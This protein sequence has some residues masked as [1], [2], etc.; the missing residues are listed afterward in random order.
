MEIDAET[1]TP[2]VLLEYGIVK[3]LRARRDEVV[4]LYPDRTARKSQAAGAG[5]THVIRFI[6]AGQRLNYVPG[7]LGSCHAR[8]YEQRYGDFT[9]VHRF[10][11]LASARRCLTA[12]VACNQFCAQLY[13]PVKLKTQMR[14]LACLF[15]LEFEQVGVGADNQ[16]PG[17]EGLALGFKKL[18]PNQ[19]APGIVNR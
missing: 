12:L 4:R 10:N 5:Q 14:V 6:E 11:P 16:T 19:R 15:R 1:A 3:T 17:P 9:N 2:P 7:C 13:R 18:R 8:R